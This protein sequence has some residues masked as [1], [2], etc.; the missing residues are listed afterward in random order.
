MKKKKSIVRY[1]DGERKVNKGALAKEIAEL[2][3]LMRKSNMSCKDFNTCAQLLSE[4][5]H[6]EFFKELFDSAFKS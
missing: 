4:T 5:D 2:D 3:E 6:V 1:V